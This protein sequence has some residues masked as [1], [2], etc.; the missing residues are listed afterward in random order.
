MTEFLTFVIVLIGG[1]T[2]YQSSKRINA[3]N[4]G[5]HKFGW[6]VMYMV[7]AGFALYCPFYVLVHAPAEELLYILFGGVLGV[8]LNI[9]LTYDQWKAGTAPPIAEKVC[10]PEVVYKDYP[11]SRPSIRDIVDHIP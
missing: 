1:W 2:A 11:E 3:L 8:A 4:P 9:A 6:R 5:K 7:F 10:T